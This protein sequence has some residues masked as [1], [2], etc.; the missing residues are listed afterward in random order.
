MSQRKRRYDTDECPALDPVAVKRLK[1]NRHDTGALNVFALE[2]MGTNHFGDGARADSTAKAGECTAKAAA[3]CELRHVLSYAL[4]S[5]LLEVLESPE[6]SKRVAAWDKAGKIWSIYRKV[7]TWDGPLRAQRAMA[8]FL[9]E[10]AGNDMATWDGERWRKATEQMLALRQMLL[11]PD[12]NASAREEQQQQPD[13]K[14][15]SLDILFSGRFSN[16]LAAME[17]CAVLAPIRQDL[18]RLVEE[19]SSLLVP[20]TALRLVL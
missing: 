7:A 4:S 15:S 9:I 11:R 10:Y 8:Q 18:E 3:L 1:S 16:V 20:S 14:F 13:V 5:F 6:L 2:V 19:N 17:A 12:F